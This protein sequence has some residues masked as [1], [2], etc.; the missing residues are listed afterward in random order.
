MKFSHASQILRD[1]PHISQRSASILYDFVRKQRPQRCLELGFAHGA[2]SNYIAAALQENGEGHLDSVDLELSR[3]FTPSMETVLE[4]TELHDWISIH[5]ESD[6]YNWFLKKTIAAQ[7]RDDV[8]EP[9]YDFCFI[10]GSKN[11][12]IDGLAFFLTDKLLRPGGWILF[13]DYAWSYADK[14]R[15]SG[16]EVTDG[17]SHSSLSADQM[18]EPNVKA[19][20]QYLVKQHP[21][22]SQF[23]IQDNSWAWACK[24][25]GAA[26]VRHRR[27]SKLRSKLGLWG[28]RLGV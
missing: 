17:V 5:R 24:R 23:T 2:S 20:F 10:D 13:D 8:C 27:K 9:I 21:D 6:S 19:I 22:Y 4:R 26:R 18:E 15:R 16:K 28:S 11:W 3:D 25:P 7:T 14:Q 1:T 12:T